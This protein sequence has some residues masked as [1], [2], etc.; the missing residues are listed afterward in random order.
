MTERG[1][2]PRRPTNI[3]LVD[4]PVA[5]RVRAH[6][7]QGL[8]ERRQIVG[9]EPG[10]SGLVIDD[11]LQMLRFGLGVEP[12]RHRS[13]DRAF[14]STSSAGIACTSPL[15]SSR[16]RRAARTARFAQARFRTARRD[17]TAASQR[18]PPSRRA[19]GSG[20]PAAGSWS[21]SCSLLRSAR[22]I[23]ILESIIDGAAWR[24]AT[25]YLPQAHRRG[26]VA[27]IRWSQDDG[28]RRPGPRHDRPT[29]MAG[30]RPAMTGKTDG[31]QP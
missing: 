2:A 19:A 10:P 17:S 20:P 27:D 5:V 13:S 6:G 12:D 24:M 14:R 18:A 4:D 25:L 1:T 26:V 7:F 29:R 15:S 22:A 31:R 16:A 23:P 28:V 21:P 11:G 8:L 30:T 9:A 3:R